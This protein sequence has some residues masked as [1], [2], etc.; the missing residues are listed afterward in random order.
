MIRYLSADYVFP[1]HS[2][3]LKDGVVAINE[4]NE[5]VALFSANHPAIPDL[6]IEKYEGFLTPGFINAH[7]H[8]ELSHLHKR[9]P[10]GTKLIPFLQKVMNLSKS[11]DQEIEKMMEWADGQMYAAGIVA[12]GDISN[13][14]HSKTIKLNS[15]I[16]YHTFVEVLGFEPEKA[17]FIFGQAKKLSEHFQPLESSITPHSPYSVSFNLF[18]RIKSYSDTHKNL[19]SIHNQES[20]EENTFFQYKAGGFVDFYKELGKDIDHFKAKSRNSLQTIASLLPDNQKVLFV[21]NTYS[22]HKDISTVLR[23][24]INAVWCFCPNANLYIEGRLPRI[25]T[26]VLYKSPIVLGTDSLASNHKLCILSEMQ[27]IVKH[28]SE[29][30]FHL[31]LQWACLNGAKYL[32]IESKYG[33][34]ELGKKPGINLINNT[35]GMNITENS[36]VTKIV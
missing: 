5:I 14:L 30:D 25:N 26:F 17:E 1:V 28:F 29:I 4:A 36:T 19:I 20:I 15:K 33:S 13:T 6:R 34:F 21:H 8:L 31:M 16:H 18:Q 11:S 22:T 2:S 12:V 24:G 9:I 3:P 32:G 10:Q 7:C 35:E 27:T 23:N